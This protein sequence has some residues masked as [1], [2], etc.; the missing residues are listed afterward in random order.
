MNKIIIFLLI[1]SLSSLFSILANAQT[2]GNFKIEIL[3]KTP[4]KEKFSTLN[5]NAFD[6]I[7]KNPIECLIIKIDKISFYSCTT[8]ILNLSLKKGR[9]SIIFGSVGYS[10]SNTFKIMTKSN[11][12]YNLKIYLTPIKVSLE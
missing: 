4:S 3:K 1:F 7:T 12:D 10:Y 11:E 5:I 9:H 6:S 8:K 2:A